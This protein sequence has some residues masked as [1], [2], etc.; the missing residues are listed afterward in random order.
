[1]NPKRHSGVQKLSTPVDVFILYLWLDGPVHSCSAAQS[2]QQ[3]QRIQIRWNQG[4]ATRDSLRFE[5]KVWVELQR[6]SCNKQLACE[7][8]DGLLLLFTAP[9]ISCIDG[10][11]QQLLWVSVVQHI[12]CT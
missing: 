4:V 2:R 12:E 8:S 10:C 3:I 9:C 7:R 6:L 11:A 1:M 5:F